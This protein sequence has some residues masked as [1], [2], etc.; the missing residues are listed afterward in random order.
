MGQGKRL[1]TP[2]EELLIVEMLEVAA[3]SA[4]PYNAD[5]LEA[6]ALNIG[7]A[8]YGSRFALGARG[9]WRKGFEKRFKDRI[10]KVKSSSICQRRAAAATEEVRD[11]VFAHFMLFCDN[12][13]AQDKLTPAQRN[14][15]GEHIGN[16]DEVGG[17]E[18]GKRKKV[19]QNKTK[20]KW[21]T[22]TRDGDHNPFHVTLMFA[23]MAKGILLPG[24][25]I[26]HSAPGSKTPRMREDLYEN[27]PNHWHCRRTVSGSMT[28]ELF[29]DWAVCVCTHSYLGL[30]MV[31]CCWPCEVPVFHCIANVA[32]HSSHVSFILI[33]HVLRVLLAM[34]RSSLSNPYTSRAMARTSRSF[35]SSTVTPHAGVT[36]A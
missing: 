20:S 13:V 34:R 25:S 33:T 31:F 27:L 9:N 12:L 35:Y 24:I 22:T 1:F 3:E 5:A 36:K 14:N 21:R 26:I 8:A 11:K 19:Y 15:L 17:D 2:H 28:R 18:R 7:K 30:L 16:A 4:F 10:A 32:N 6:S 23:S 29:K